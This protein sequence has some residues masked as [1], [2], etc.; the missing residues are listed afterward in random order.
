MR[1]P[2]NHIRSITRFFH[3]ELAGSYSAEEVE[4]FIFYSFEHYLGFYRTDL[5][6]KAN[7]T[8]TESELLKFNDV[9]KR[10]K[11][12]EP[13]QYILGETWFYGLKLNVNPAVLIPRP[14]TEELVDWIVKEVGSLP[15]GQAGRK[16][17]GRSVGSIL[18]VGT[19]SGCIAIA[20]KKNI[21]NAEV[22]ALDI[23]EEALDVARQ[24]ATINNV[25][26][27][28]IQTDILENKLLFQHFNSFD[29]I[30]SNPPY[31]LRSEKQSMEA[32]VLEHEPHVALFVNDNDPLLFYRTIVQFTQKHLA[33]AGKLFFEINEAQ[34]DEVRNLLLQSGFK[35][36]VVK[37]DLSGKERMVRA[38]K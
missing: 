16:S 27:N 17:E 24:N 13:I 28:F 31:I 22:F 10:L 21:P 35:N 25:D 8:I 37:K 15:A 12:Q 32:N 23:S 3:D 19:G 5:S 29:I 14:E 2:S 20:L 9:V 38:E 7:D 26:V 4:N 36:V 1:I 18:D 11:R 6:L 30:V 33:D 34:A